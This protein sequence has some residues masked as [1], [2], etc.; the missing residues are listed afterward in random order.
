MAIWAG[1]WFAGTLAEELRGRGILSVTFGAAFV[2]VSHPRLPDEI[3]PTTDF[4]YL[5][6]HGLGP[7]LYQYHYTRPELSRWARRLTPL[8][9]EGRR[10]YAFF[11][12]DYQ[13]NAPQNAQT[14]STLFPRAL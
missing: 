12:N 14:F 5:R 13:A 11:N 10:V 8:L 1:L 3:Y 9:G 2:A 4:L 6:F 7:Q